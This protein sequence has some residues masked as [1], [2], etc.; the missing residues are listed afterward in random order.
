MRGS[1]SATR[2]ECA[3]EAVGAKSSKAAATQN[4]SAGT[5]AAGTSLFIN[6]CSDRSV[7]LSGASLNGGLVADHH[8]PL[9]V[10]LDPQTADM[11]GLPGIRL[12]QTRPPHGIAEIKHLR[13][14]QR[15]GA[16]PTPNCF[17]LSSVA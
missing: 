13:G 5:F 4:T 6:V 11:H 2:W 12:V 15:D 10:A 16:E 3:A 8:H 14:N 7:R 1:A 17:C 9:A